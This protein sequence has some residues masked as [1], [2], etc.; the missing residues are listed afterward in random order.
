ML[1]NLKVLISWSEKFS[2]ITTRFESYSELLSHSLEIPNESTSVE[3][4]VNELEE[5]SNILSAGRCDNYNIYYSGKF[6]IIPCFCIIVEH[7]YS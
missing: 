2:V 7:G 1:K 4:S 5:S 3:I 6:Y